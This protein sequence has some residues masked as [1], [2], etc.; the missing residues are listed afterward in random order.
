MS[1]NELF[2]NGQQPPLRAVCG[3]E[4]QEGGRQEGGVPGQPTASGALQEG[5]IPA[6]LSDATVRDGGV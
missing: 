3:G 2:V 5:N 4:E 1:G 6:G